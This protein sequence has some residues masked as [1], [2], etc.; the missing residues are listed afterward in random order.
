MIL[1]NFMVEIFKIPQVCWSEFQ[2]NLSIFF[3]K[4]KILAKKYKIWA[5]F[6]YDFSKKKKFSHRKMSQVKKMLILTTHLTEKNRWQRFFV[7]GGNSL[8]KNFLQCSKK[9]FFH[10]TYLNFSYFYNN[11]GK[12]WWKKIF[13]K[14]FFS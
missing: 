9:K 7:D 2:K 8:M 12:N 5:N 6:L 4:P 11:R 1:K 10:H 3:A 14:K 13:L